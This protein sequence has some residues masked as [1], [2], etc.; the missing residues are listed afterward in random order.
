MSNTTVFTGTYW[1]IKC[2]ST[3]DGRTLQ[4][5]I[6]FQPVAAFGREGVGQ[7]ADDGEEG[8]S[9]SWGTVKEQTHVVL[10]SSK[11]IVLFQC[12]SLLARMFSPVAQ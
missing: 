2:V 8:K 7:T 11:E 10:S 1:K 5:N 3:A 4:R 6:S 9:R 12:M